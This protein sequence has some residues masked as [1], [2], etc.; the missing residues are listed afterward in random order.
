MFKSP[1]FLQYLLLIGCWIACIVGYLMKIYPAVVIP[2]A[3]MILIMGGIIIN[4]QAYT[5]SGS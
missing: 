4:K 1:I 2:I 5:R 3:S